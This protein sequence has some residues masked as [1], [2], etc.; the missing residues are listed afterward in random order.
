MLIIESLDDLKAK[1]KAVTATVRS[2]EAGSTEEKTDSPL[3]ECIR[4]NMDSVDSDLRPIF[5]ALVKAIE[6]R[7]VNFEDEA[8]EYSYPKYSAVVPLEVTGGHDYPLNCAFIVNRKGS[9]GQARM[10]IKNDPEDRLGNCLCGAWRYATDEE[11]DDL[12][13]TFT[14]DEDIPSMLS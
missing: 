7:E 12:F 2:K 4:E 14:E 6:G 11:I 1:V 10:G 3:V 8:V 13:A 5:S 9:D